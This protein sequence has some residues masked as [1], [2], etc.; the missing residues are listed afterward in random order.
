MHPN[1]RKIFE[2]ARKKNLRTMSLRS[3]AGELGITH[4]QTVKFHL[5]KLINMQIL[6]ENWSVIKSRRGIFQ[7]PIYGT[8]NC[9]PA[10]F[11]A[12]NE[13]LGYLRV[14]SGVLG[15]TSAKNLIA[16]R[17][18]GNSM[19]RAF[20]GRG[21]HDSDY[22]LVELVSARDIRH[23]EYV[24]S[25]FD[26]CANIKKIMIDKDHVSFVSE[27]SEEYPP[28]IVTRAELAQGLVRVVG[29]VVKVIRTKKS[30]TN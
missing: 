24:V 18:D 1:Q 29:R 3:I 7:I 4:P 27:S 26:G 13:I 22:V 8:A 17:A 16:L 30:K 12:E 23:G 19:N 20:G 5:Q 6:N 15:R 21:I 10:T 14:S 9:G 28:V 25:L 11:H 2:L